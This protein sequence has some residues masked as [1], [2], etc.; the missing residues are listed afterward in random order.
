[1]LAMLLSLSSEGEALRLRSNFGIA[2]E[3]SLGILVVEFEHH[4]LGG[5]GCA[6]SPCTTLRTIRITVLHEVGPGSEHLL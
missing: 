1:M 2:E 5:L 6:G 3:R 4:E